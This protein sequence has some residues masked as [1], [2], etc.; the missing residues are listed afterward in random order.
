MKLRIIIFS[1]FL[2]SN[3]FAQDYIQYQRIINRIDEDILKKE[4]LS[5]IDRLD[6]LYQNFNFIYSRHCFKALQICCVLKD[7]IHADKWLKKSFIQGVPIWMVRNND[8]T[9]NVFK[10]STSQTTIQQ[11]DSLRNIYNNSI[12]RQLRNKID[13]L[14]EIDQRYTKKVNDGFV[15]LRYTY[16]NIR[17][18]KNNKKQFEILNEIFD[19]YGYPGEKL[20]GLSTSIEDSTQFYKHMNFYGPVLRETNTYY[21]LINYYSNPRADINMELLKNI[22]QGNLPPYQYG[23]INDF[24]ARW[25]KKKYGDFKYYNVW[26]QDPDK[27]NEAEIERRRN[28]IGLNSFEQQKINEMIGTENRKNKTANSEIILE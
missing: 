26:H 7:S 20:I 18:L 22:K 23:A 5:A 16:H 2:A 13:S 15:L 25:G 28:S 27:L 3:V 1:I 19:Q 21:M 17:W 6:S 4:Y 14:F 8:L 12:N 24:M 10:Y 9:K 11:Y